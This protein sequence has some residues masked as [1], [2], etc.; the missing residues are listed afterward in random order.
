MANLA[1]DRPRRTTRQAPRSPYTPEPTPRTSKRT[2]SKGKA[3]QGSSSGR[4]SQ[5]NK[6]KSSKRRKK[7]PEPS[8]D[9]LFEEA[10]AQNVDDA[11]S[12]GKSPLHSFSPDHSLLVDDDD[13]EA[14]PIVVDVEPADPIDVMGELIFNSIA[15]NYFSFTLTKAGE[16]VGDGLFDKLTALF[17]VNMSIEPS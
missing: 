7:T 3:P 16:H 13:I 17:E 2:P 8:L 1:A 12:E 11:S 9:E 14:A 4:S 10:V 5:P 6:E 15:V